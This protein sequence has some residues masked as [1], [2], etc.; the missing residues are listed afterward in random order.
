MRQR[1]EPLEP[2]VCSARV[3]VAEGLR[4]VVQPA[5]RLFQAVEVPALLGREGSR[6][7]TLLRLCALV[8]HMIGVYS[9]VGVTRIT[10]G[11]RHFVE[12]PECFQR[13]SPLIEKPLL[14]MC[15]LF[16]GEGHIRLRACKAW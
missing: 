14:E 12:K 5:Q 6:L 8:R 3:A 11:L 2:N 16:L 7:L 1:I 15:E 13:A 10:I 9:Q 4:V